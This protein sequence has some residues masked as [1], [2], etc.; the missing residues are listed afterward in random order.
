MTRYA[1]PN[2]YGVSLAFQL[3]N[4]IVMMGVDFREFRSVG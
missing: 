1:E 3:E 4:A 2:E